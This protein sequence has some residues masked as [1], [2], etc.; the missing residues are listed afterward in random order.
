MVFALY[1]LRM[2]YVYSF[3]IASANFTLNDLLGHLI[4]LRLILSR[5]SSL[6][7]IIGPPAAPGAHYSPLIKQ[8]G[9]HMH[10]VPPIHMPNRINS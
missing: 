2:Y 4:G 6:A 5:D 3:D 7:C 8:C 10:T 9:L 1:V